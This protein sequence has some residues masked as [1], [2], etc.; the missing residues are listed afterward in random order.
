MVSIDKS[1]I[2]VPAL[3]AADGKGW[4]AVEL[5]KTAYDGGTRSFSFTSKIYGHKSVKEALKA[6]QHDKCCFCEARVA[7]VSHGDVEHFRP[8]AGF[9]VLSGKKMVLFKPGYYWLAYDFRN[10]YFTCQICNQSFKKNY[11]PLADE[12]L[13]AYSHR[14]D[15]ELEICLILDPGKEN[16]ADHLYFEQE[17][18]K[19]KNGSVKGS[20]TIKRTGLDRKKLADNRLEYFRIL[21]TLAKVARGTNPEA[22]E[23][24]TLFKTLGQPQSIYSLMVRSNFPDL[25]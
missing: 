9:T 25:V 19:A 1:G 17:I 12:A 20:E 16:P 13:R 23:A 7:H 2:S 6:L 18:V 22:A 4:Q 11:F 3:L 14:H 21:D 24:Q 10:L 5:F 15:C 8:K